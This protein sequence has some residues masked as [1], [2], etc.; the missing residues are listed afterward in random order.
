RKGLSLYSTDLVREIGLEIRDVLPEGENALY[1]FIDVAG[2]LDETQLRGVLEPL[3][4]AREQ[5]TRLMQI[6]LW[7]G[8]LG[9][10]REDGEVEYIYSLNYDMRLLMGKIRRA[11]ERAPDRAVFAVNPAFWPGLGIRQS[12]K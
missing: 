8:V 9:F 2:R 3:N 4:L 6:L 10:V 5:V 7:Y 11:V 1:A 12:T